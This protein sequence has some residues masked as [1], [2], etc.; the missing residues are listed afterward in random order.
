MQWTATSTVDRKDLLKSGG[1]NYIFGDVTSQFASFD[2]KFE[3]IFNN[4]IVKIV[5]H[6]PEASTV[7]I[8]NN[9]ITLSDAIE[10]H[11]IDLA[12]MG[13]ALVWVNKP[14]VFVDLL[15]G[16]KVFLELLPHL[17]KCLESSVLALA[18][19]F[20][21]PIPESVNEGSEEE[22]EQATFLSGKPIWLSK[23]PEMQLVKKLIP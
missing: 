21:L 12:G 9:R 7:P 18:M 16:A 10:K 11:G 6:S 13:G 22:F 19:H 20:D 4:L 14:Y 2:K 3:G 8:L 15:A 23:L 17:D 5:M 1:P